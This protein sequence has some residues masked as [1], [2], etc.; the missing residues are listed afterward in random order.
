MSL[1]VDNHIIN[2]PFAEPTRYWAYGARQPV[3]KEE[4]RPEAHPRRALC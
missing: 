4:C 2:S 3:L 1:A